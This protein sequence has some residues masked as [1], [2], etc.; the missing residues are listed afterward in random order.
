[1]PFVAVLDGDAQAVVTSIQEVSG[2][3][4]GFPVTDEELDGFENMLEI[5]APDMPS[6]DRAALRT[7]CIRVMV[8]EDG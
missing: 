1:M 4:F 7:I 8:S 2:G 3:N 6:E 5:A